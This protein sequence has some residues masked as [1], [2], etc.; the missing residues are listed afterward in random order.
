MSYTFVIAFLFFFSPSTTS[1]FQRMHTILTFLT[2]F[3]CPVATFDFAAIELLVTSISITLVPFLDA[4]C[5]LL[6][7]YSPKW[8]D[9]TLYFNGIRPE[10]FFLHLFLLV[11]GVGS[12]HTE[13][14]LSYP[15]TFLRQ[16][17]NCCSHRKTL[18]CVIRITYSSYLM[19]LIIFLW[20]FNS[21]QFAG[22]NHKTTEECLKLPRRTSHANKERKA[23]GLL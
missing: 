16:A 13:F 2:C 10:T 6:S 8:N 22:I 20:A 18:H 12:Q 1:F 15:P 4:L 14:Y 19:W 9:P 21:F 17:V 23:M 11:S 5:P 3:K 7:R